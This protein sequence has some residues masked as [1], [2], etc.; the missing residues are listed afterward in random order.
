LLYCSFVL[1]CKFPYPFSVGFPL[2]FDWVFLLLYNCFGEKYLQLIL[3]GGR[4]GV[5][6]FLPFL[7][8]G[9]FW[10]FKGGMYMEL[11]DAMTWP[12]G[13]RDIHVASKIRTMWYG[14][15]ERWWANNLS[16][17][18][19]IP[20]F[21]FCS[22]LVLQCLFLQTLFSWCRDREESTHSISLQLI[23]LIDDDDL[24]L[25]EIVGFRLFR[26]CLPASVCLSVGSNISCL[27]CFQQKLDRIL[28][29]RL[30]LT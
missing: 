15:I 23:D 27:A 12:R 26:Q 19:S 6:V 20:S 10:H 5:I 18:L 13:I 2:F 1:G 11:Y 14:V 3:F 7:F 8:T 9:V 25:C 16:C 21:F 17:T 22:A 29:S 28:L 4:F 24:V 30:I